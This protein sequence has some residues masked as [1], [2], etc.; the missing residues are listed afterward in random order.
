[1]L[2]LD[3][4]LVFDFL[5]IHVGVANAPLFIG[6]IG[7]RNAVIAF[8]AGQLNFTAAQIDEDL[9]DLIEDGLLTNKPYVPSSYSG[10]DAQHLG[11]THN[12]WLEWPHFCPLF[13]SHWGFTRTLTFDDWLTWDGT[14][15]PMAGYYPE[16]FVLKP[17]KEQKYRSLTDPWSPTSDE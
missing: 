3:N 7:Q 14:T 6:S 10:Q 8:L 12:G 2:G 13:V 1:M 4:R 15:G 17:K 11:V 16:V 9:S 5:C